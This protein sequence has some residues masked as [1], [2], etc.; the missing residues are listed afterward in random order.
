MVKRFCNA[1][2]PSLKIEKLRVEKTDNSSIKHE[3]KHSKIKQQ[4]K[5]FSLTTQQK[6]ELHDNMFR[7]SEDQ[8]RG[9]WNIISSDS[10]TIKD[11]KTR[12]RCHLNKVSPKTLRE[13]YKYVNTKILLN[14]QHMKKVKKG[15]EVLHNEEHQR[16]DSDYQVENNGM[17]VNISQ[18]SI[19][20]DS[21]IGKL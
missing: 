11:G 7:L 8:L 20:E 15:Q 9:I 14:Q 16:S 2:L 19:N 5:E 3:N 21:L 13:L 17:S 18:D 1:H 12:I 6:T 10:K 4:S